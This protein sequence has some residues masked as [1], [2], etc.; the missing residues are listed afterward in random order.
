MWAL[1]ENVIRNVSNLL[2]RYMADP[3]EVAVV[4][5]YREM[6]VMAEQMLVYFE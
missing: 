4:K 6:V 2:L 3:M 5:G 1:F